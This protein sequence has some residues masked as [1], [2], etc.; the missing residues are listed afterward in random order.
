MAKVRDVM[1]RNPIRV[2]VH[3]P[4]VEAAE[5]MQLK[6][7]RHVVVMEG[8]SPVG[9]ISWSD[10]GTWMSRGSPEDEDELAPVGEI[11]TPNPYLVL[12]DETVDAV[13]MEMAEVGI[14][15]G[16]VLDQGCVCGLILEGAES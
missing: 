13:L 11:M 2:G 8:G 14:A 3:T 7:V 9:T 15:A 4:I 5:V 1:S 6:A 16:I 10:V 12:A